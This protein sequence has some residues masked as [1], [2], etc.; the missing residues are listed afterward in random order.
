MI[1]CQ[2]NITVRNDKHG[3]WFILECPCGSPDW[4]KAVLGPINVLR[5]QMLGHRRNLYE[6]D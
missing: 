1:Q 3:S 2:P 5:I 4:N 6:E